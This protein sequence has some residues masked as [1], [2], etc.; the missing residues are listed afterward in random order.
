MKIGKRT[1]ATRRTVRRQAQEYRELLE[2]E[3]QDQDLGEKP[4]LREFWAT[5][6][7]KI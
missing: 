4:D 6:R 5:D 2:S 3:R 1:P 7:Q